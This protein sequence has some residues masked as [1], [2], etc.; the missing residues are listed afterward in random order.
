LI[1]GLLIWIAFSLT[2]LSRPLL[3]GNPPSPEQL[4]GSRAP[5]E[6]A[7]HLRQ[8]PI[9]GP[10][11]APPWWNDWLVVH[12]QPPLAPLV[13]SHVGRVPRQIWLDYGRVLASEDGWQDVLDR[14]QI[15]SLV[16]DRSRQRS[17]VGLLRMAPE[18]EV[19]FQDERAILFRR[20]T[21]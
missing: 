14:Y 3:G 12:V 2:G 7:E 13:T 11:F 5:L 15:N 20:K 18:W 19:G 8:N 16:A 21:P 1:C 4:Y 10:V 6:L 9:S 17:L